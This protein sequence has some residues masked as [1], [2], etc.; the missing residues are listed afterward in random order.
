MRD[1]ALLELRP[2]LGLATVN[3]TEIEAFQNVTLRPILKIQNKLTAKLLSSSEH[4]TK[5]IAKA[6]MPD[7]KAYQKAVSEFITSNLV[8]KNRL[9][10]VV[11]A[12]MTEDELDFYLAHS[13]ELNKRILT[14][15]IQRF[16]DNRDYSF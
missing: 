12:L 14:M 9:V 16:V 1:K 6:D 10:G 4:F 8:F 3:S 11:I 5:I 2:E 7:I 13:S 15:Q